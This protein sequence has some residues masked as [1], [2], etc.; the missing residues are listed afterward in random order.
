MAGVPVRIHGEHGRDVGDLD[1]SS[2]RYQRVRRVYRPFVTRYVALSPRSRSTICASA[3]ASRRRG[4][5]RSTTA[6][7]PRAFRPPTGGAAPIDGCPFQSAGSLAGRH[8]RP[9]GDRQGPGQI[10]REPSCARSHA[11]PRPAR[12]CAR[13][14]RRRAAAAESRRYSSRRRA[15]SGVVAGERDDVPDLLRGLDCFVLPSL[16]EGVSNTIL[17]AMA[18]GLPVVA[19]RGRRQRRAGRGRN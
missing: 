11:I 2:L 16:A 17:E 7:I 3:L 10:W 12:A 18:C 1:G 4:S 6:S 8:R 15:R 5:S 9:H 19:T 14:G 13:D